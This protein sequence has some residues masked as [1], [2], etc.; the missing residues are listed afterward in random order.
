[1]V[2]VD[3]NINTLVKLHRKVGNRWQPTP[4]YHAAYYRNNWIKSQI[5]IKRYTSRIKNIKFDISE[6]D[7]ILPDICPVLGIPLQIWEGN[8][9]R[10]N[11]P[12]IDRIDPKKGYIKGNVC[13]IS[14]KANRIKND[15]TVEE[16]EKVL[17]WLKK[18]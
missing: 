2:I 7:L 9:P 12:S 8:G 4:E 11:S 16:L 13:I 18:Q 3:K 17:Q 14:M 6:N 5:R 15:A 10:D 1:M